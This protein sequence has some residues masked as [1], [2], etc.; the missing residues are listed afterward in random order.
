[1]N[2]A[3]FSEFP[4]I[5]KDAWLA[6]AAKDLKGKNFDDTLVWHP[7]EDFD[8]Q[9]YYAQEDLETLP[10][11]QIQAAQRNKK[12]GIIQNRIL[13]KFI[14]ERESNNLIINSLQ[15]G[16]DAVMVDFGEIPVS[17]INLV[18]LLNNVKLSETPIYFKTQQKNELL[19]NLLK[20]VSYQPKGGFQ[21]DFLAQSF[22]ATNHAIST[23]T[24]ENTK[25]LIEKTA[26][27]PHFQAFSIESHVYHNAGANA[28]QELAFTLASAV[29]YL[30]K[31][32]NLGLTP[33]QIIPK[34]SFSISIGTNYFMEIAKLRA[35]R[36]LWSKILD[37]YNVSDQIS[38]CLVHGQTSS[39]YE[40][41]LSPYTNMLRT[42]TEAMSGIMGGCDSLTVLAYDGSENNEFAQRIARNVTT[43]MQEEAHLDKTI[44]P[45]AGSY[46]VENLT[47]KLASEAWTLFQKIEKMGGIVASFEQGFMKEEISKS[48][49]N[50]VKNLQNGKVM[51]GVN[52]FRV[53][54]EK[55]LKI[56]EN[57]TES[58]IFLQNR[59]VSEIFE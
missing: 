26:Q 32:T 10:I 51:V 9:P 40:A 20:F 18:R 3:L 4:K 23:S 35:L 29:E 16:A 44:D 2:P 50:R 17:E 42:T 24:W 27:F 55:D 31:L 57:I 36:Y 38:S 22:F 48:Y 59:R 52:K 5:T 45:S 58:S 54:P 30:D 14:D 25:Y 15:S 28:V 6:Q 41:K 53:E 1:M 19:E 7:T 21:T 47:H 37:A 46:Y 43:L 8:I 56:V 39:F 34:F 13:V 49:E 11:E 33:E 12:S